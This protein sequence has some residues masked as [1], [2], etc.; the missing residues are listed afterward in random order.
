VWWH[1]PL[2]RDFPALLPGNLLDLV[3]RAY[4]LVEVGGLLGR[5][6]AQ[7]GRDFEQLF[8]DLC[9]RRGIHLC[10]R[11]GAR[12][13]AQSRSAS[14]LPH[15]VDGATRAV[16]CITH[17]ELKHLTMGVPKNELLIFNGKGLDF[18]QGS[19]PLAAR[20]PVLRFLLSGAGVRDECR[21][22]AV[23]WGIMIVEPFRLPLPLLYE[24]VARGAAACLS[25]AECDVVRDRAYWAC[26]PLQK[27]IRELHEWSSAPRGPSPC[28][29]GALRIAKEVLDVQ[30]QIG[31]TVVDYLDENF[32]DWLDDTAEE[33]WHAVGGW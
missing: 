31:A 30:E 21:Y 1:R 10:E 25:P 14:G 16:D 17:W 12:T 7:R 11:A 5:C 29:P 22:F 19:R 33:T 4:A 28:G 23:L 20:T 6:G 27:V 8:Y 24:A 3:A 15:E 13:V 26:R 18:L 9:D 2:L 32:N